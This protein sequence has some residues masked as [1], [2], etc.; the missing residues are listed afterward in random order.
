MLNSNLIRTIL[1]WLTGGSL[2]WIFTDLLRC[3]GDTVANATCAASFIPAEYKAIA[4][5]AF[6]VVG[7]L[8][9]MFGGSGATVAQNIA[10]PVVPVVPEAD[11]KVGVVTPK[12]VAAS[13]PSK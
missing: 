3:T 10:A 4:G 2:T 8:L 6:V 11:A 12:Q 5:M 1:N 7:F 13:G 9:K